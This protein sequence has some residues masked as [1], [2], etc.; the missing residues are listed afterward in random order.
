M[1]ITNVTLTETTPEATELMSTLITKALTSTCESTCFEVMLKLNA[2]GEK[3]PEALAERVLGPRSDFDERMK[4]IEDE[5]FIYFLE[6]KLG[7]HTTDE[8]ELRAIA[9]ILSIYQC[10]EQYGGCEC[11][12]FELLD[13]LHEKADKYGMRD[14]VTDSALESLA[15]E[16]AYNDWLGRSNLSA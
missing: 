4:A 16:L 2:A 6:E 8:H 14:C 5:R 12:Y 10:N 15:Y 7:E 1:T 3:I 11:E 9:T 13:V